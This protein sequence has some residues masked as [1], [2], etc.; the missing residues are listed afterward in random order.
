MRFFCRDT[1]QTTPSIVAGLLWEIPFSMSVFA[2]IPDFCDDEAYA[3]VGL[4]LTSSRLPWWLLILAVRQLTCLLDRVLGRYTQ[5][6]RIQSNDLLPP[7]QIKQSCFLCEELWW[8]LVHFS[9]EIWIQMALNYWTALL[10]TRMGY[11]SLLLEEFHDT[12]LMRQNCFTGRTFYPG[13]FWVSKKVIWPFNLPWYNHSQY[14]ASHK[15]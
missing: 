10:N 11:S 1:D 7:S 5:V 6:K 12:H 13:V 14:P 8:L 9:T 2:T 3:E 4:L 15:L